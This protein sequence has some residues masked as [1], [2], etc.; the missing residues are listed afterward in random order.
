MTFALQEMKIVLSALFARWRLT[1]EPGQRVIPRP[2]VTLVPREPIRMRVSAAE[3][4][5]AAG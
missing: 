4:P 3:A 1:L 2:L 5:V